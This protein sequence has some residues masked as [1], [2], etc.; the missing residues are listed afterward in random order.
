VIADRHHLYFGLPD[1]AVA[2]CTGKRQNINLRQKAGATPLEAMM[3][4]GQSRLQ[5]TWDYNIF[6]DAAQEEEQLVRM[7]GRLMGDGTG[8]VQ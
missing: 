2:V 4:A 8:E 3:A 7:W 6:A 1:G 5:A